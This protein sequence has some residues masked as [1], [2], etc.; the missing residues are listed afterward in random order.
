MRLLLNER[1]KKKLWARRNK[2]PDAD[3]LIRENHDMKTPKVLIFVS[4]EK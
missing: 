4:I 2:R 3:K 1:S